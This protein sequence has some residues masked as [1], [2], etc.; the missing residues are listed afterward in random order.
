MLLIV[1]P[2][3]LPFA[4][5]VL[6]QPIWFIQQEVVPFSFMHLHSIFLPEPSFIS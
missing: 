5:Q 3:Q 4:L 2:I 6:S 1:L